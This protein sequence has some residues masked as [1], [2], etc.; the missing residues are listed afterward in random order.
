MHQ[1]KVFKPNNEKFKKVLYLVGFWQ[2]PT[3]GE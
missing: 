2:P 3:R 1:A